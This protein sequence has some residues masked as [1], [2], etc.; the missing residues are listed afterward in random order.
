MN[1][2]ANGLVSATTSATTPSHAR[3]HV[4]PVRR[5]SAR[6]CAPG[7]SERRRSSQPRTN[8]TASRAIPA[9]FGSATNDESGGSGSAAPVG[10]TPVSAPAQRSTPAHSQ[11]SIRVRKARIAGRNARAL[12]RPRASRSRTPSANGTIATT[13]ASRTVH[14]LAVRSSRKTLSGVRNAATDAGV[15]RRDECLRRAP[16]L[17]EPP[18]GECFGQSCR[19]RT[20]ARRVAGRERDRGDP[21]GNERPVLGGGVGHAQID[22][23]RENR[24]DRR[25]LP[26]LFRD[27]CGR[28]PDERPRRRA[29][30]VPCECDARSPVRSDI[31]ERDYGQRFPRERRRPREADRTGPSVGARIGRDEY[32]RAVRKRR[33][34][35]SL[36]SE[37]TS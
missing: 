4:E 25:R 36:G 7:T 29:R 19:R 9:T 34:Q 22:E 16:Q 15:D 24:R 35:R 18:L 1:T 2:S 26:G 37:S 32:E 17:T 11:T 30:S 31:V 13:R 3:A 10:K 6:A 27:P 8:A 33:G 28:R 21:L 5:S 23:L 20:I 12:R 14:P